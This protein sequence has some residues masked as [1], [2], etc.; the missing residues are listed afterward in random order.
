MAKKCAFS[1]II[2]NERGERTLKAFV[3]KYGY[4]ICLLF[5]IVILVINYIVLMENVTEETAL[6]GN[7]AGA[8]TV[9][10]DAGHGGED[11]GAVSLTG[12]LEKDINLD[13]AL[14]T[15]QIMALCGI[16]PEMTRDSD[17]IDYPESAKTTRARKTADT[18]RR[19][20]LVN[21]T[22]RCVFIS[23]HQNKYGSNTS[24]HGAQVFYAPTDGSHA[25]AEKI[26]GIFLT[27]LDTSN[28]RTAV[29]IP[30]EIYNE[31]DIFDIHD[32]PVPKNGGL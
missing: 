14:K 11:G 24:P 26:Q 27:E 16:S 23:I 19:A 18:N 8:V 3:F 1:H 29:Q 7:G 17:I 15:E 2:E 13:I 32:I 9:I 25:F 31:G 4:I 10:I 5:I 6:T 30:D 22:D 28:K 20:E 12:A 21:S